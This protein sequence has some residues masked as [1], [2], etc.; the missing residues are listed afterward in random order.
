MTARFI[1][2]RTGIDSYDVKRPTERVLD[3]GCGNGNHVMY[4]AEQGL[5]AAGI[6]ISQSAI[7]IARERAN[8]RGLDVE[9][10]TGSAETLQWTDDTFDLVVSDGVLDHVSFIE[11]KRIVDEVQCVS[12]PN[13]YIFLSLRSTAD[14]ECGRGEQLEEN[15]YVLQEGYEEGMIQ[16]FFDRQHIAELLADYDIFDIEH[17]KREYPTEFTIDKSHR[18]SSGGIKNRLLSL[19]QPSTGNTPAGGWP[20]SER[21]KSN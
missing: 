20:Q 13:A 9:L 2:R 7:D 5:S 18:Q 14:S 15:T 12:T 19:T 17:I 8:R 11:A 3:I 21:S 4:F 10:E 6:D 1:Q 16:H